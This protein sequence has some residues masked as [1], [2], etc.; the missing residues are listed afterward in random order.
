M[1]Q[2]FR[3]RTFFGA[4]VIGI[5]CAV[6][7]EHGKISA[8]QPSTNSS[9]PAELRYTAD[10]RQTAVAAQGV[11]NPLRSTSSPSTVP[12]TARDKIPKSA[13]VSPP[14]P[15]QRFVPNTGGLRVFR[16]ADKPSGMTITNGST[17][18]GP[19]GV[20]ASSSRGDLFPQSKFA[21]STRPPLRVMRFADVHRG[22]AVVPVTSPQR[23][24][25][26]AA[27]EAL[28]SSPSSSAKPPSKPTEQEPK[29]RRLPPLDRTVAPATLPP[30]TKL[31]QEPIKIYP[32]TGL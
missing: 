7:T 6:A 14:P 27:A 1:A 23:A 8:A 24:K 30:G 18:D 32:T 19:V 17:S 26:K 16:R 12:T 2:P 28:A 9:R 25:A 4:L 15:A 22:A 31:P 10:S 11:A 29:L 21:A 20:T 13:V 3:A 5:V